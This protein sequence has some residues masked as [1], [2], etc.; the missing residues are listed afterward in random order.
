MITAGSVTVV[1]PDGAERVLEA[2]HVMVL[3]AG[4][5]HALRVGGEGCDITD[6]YAPVRE[7]VQASVIDQEYAARGTHEDSD[8]NHGAYAELQARLA[9]VDIKIG[10]KEIM[11]VPLDLLTRYAYDKQAVS[12]GQI[13]DILGLTKQEAKQLIRK[14]KHGDDHSEY[15]LQRKKERLVIVPTPLAGKAETGSE[16]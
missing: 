7:D 11:D 9:D 4:V 3:Q 2:G 8:P 15:S 5:P 10:L 14:W 6:I 1:F 13:R 12:M 16:S